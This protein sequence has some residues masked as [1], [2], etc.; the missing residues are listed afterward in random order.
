M[1]KPAQKRGRRMKRKH[2]E[3]AEDHV[4]SSAKRQ[5]S[6]DAAE[7]STSDQNFVPLYAQDEDM[8][9]AYPGGEKAFFGMLDDDEQEFFK[10]ADQTLEADSFEGPEARANFLRSVFKEAEGKELKIAQSQSCSRVLERLIRV[11]TASQLKGLFQKFSG[12]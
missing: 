8:T 4:E 9:A 5:K 2:E 10:Q 7:N 11:A 1:P 6:G 12:K 3:E